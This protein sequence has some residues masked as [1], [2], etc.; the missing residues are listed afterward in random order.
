MTF[1]LLPSKKQFHCK[2]LEV[3]PLPRLSQVTVIWNFLVVNEIR[4][5]Q[6]QKINI[7]SVSQQVIATTPFCNWDIHDCQIIDWRCGLKHKRKKIRIFISKCTLNSILIQWVN[8]ISLKK[9]RYNL[10]IT[11]Y[12]WQCTAM[13]PHMYTL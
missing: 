7:L 6:K 4:E 12:L 11:S 9:L 13:I 2:L 3:H 10:Y 1:C 5:F 8:Q